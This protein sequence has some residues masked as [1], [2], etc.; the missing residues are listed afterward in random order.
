MKSSTTIVTAY[1]DIG[2]GEWTANKGFRE[3]LARSADVYLDY[4]KRLAA[5]END[6]IVFTSP[7]L[8]ERIEAI[9][10]ENQPPSSRLILRKNLGTSEAGS[11]K[12]KKTA[13]SQRN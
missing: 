7:D 6:M 8:K 5:L 9:R 3:K 11:K 2:R 12:F 10:E 13:I 1:F 4:F